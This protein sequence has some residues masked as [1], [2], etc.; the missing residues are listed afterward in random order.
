[1]SDIYS[2]EIKRHLITEDNYK[3]AND[4]TISEILNDEKSADKLHQEKVN[5][6][7]EVMGWVKL[8]LVVEV[9]Y[10]PAIIDSKKVKTKRLKKFVLDQLNKDV[11]HLR[12][13]AD[14]SENIN[15]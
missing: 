12:W 2:N 9:I 1:M 5:N 7:Y 14:R 10:E 6:I 11:R 15:I 13:E 8:I 4:I 3:R